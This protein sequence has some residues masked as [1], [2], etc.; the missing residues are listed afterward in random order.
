[1]ADTVGSACTGR[2]MTRSNSAGNSWTCMSVD[3]STGGF[4][5][6]SYGFVPW[7]QRRAAATAPSDSCQKPDKLVIDGAKY[8]I[9]GLDDSH[10][11]KLVGVSPKQ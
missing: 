2:L 6:I 9:T 10:V 11:A 5:G 8:N 1:M 7:K 3:H 4:Q